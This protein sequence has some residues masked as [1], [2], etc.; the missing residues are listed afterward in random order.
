MNEILLKAIAA[1]EDGN[2]KKAE[3]FY[4]TVLQT[5]PSS[6]NVNFNLGVLLAQLERLD[7]AEKFYKKAI[8]SKPD[9][10]EAHNNLGILFD[11]TE[12][13]EDSEECYKKAILSKPDFAEAHNNLGN[14]LF[15][16]GKLKDSEEC[17]KKA[18]TLK[19]DF[20]DAH[21]NICKL[22]N[23]RKEDQQLIQMQKLYEDQSL[24]K[25]KHIRLCFTLGKVFED[26]NEINKSFRYYTEGNS[27]HKKTLNY[28]IKQD[29]QEF[30]KLKKSYKDIKKISIKDITLA[31]EPK[32]IFIVG[33]PR[34]GTSL[35][36]QIISSHSKVTGAGELS[37]IAE[38]GHSIAVGDSRI[39]AE[40]IL[41][42]RKKYLKKIQ[43]LSNENSVVIDKMPANF[44][45][46]GL[47]STAFPKAK[48][49]HVKRDSAATCWGNYK[50]FFNREVNLY[51][52]DLND[53]IIYYKLYLNLMNLWKREYGKQIYTLNY[54]SL[55][56]K[57]EYKTRKLIEFLDLEWE[58][59]CLEPENN[60]RRVNTASKRQIR[61]K[62]YQNSSAEWKKFEPFLNG[63]F[64]QLDNNKS[65][66]DKL[67]NLI[68]SIRKFIG[69]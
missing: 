7:E 24:P 45:Y 31:T 20:V 40:A 19:P 14:K 22:K 25:E 56:I 57:Q 37:Y 11:K 63:I 64:N 69:F 28:S 18:L 5:H 1:H 15:E 38:F 43:K 41:N 30:K 55:V 54:E 50:N 23:F 16:I 6:L 62:V 2:F 39:D 3:S 42:F 67:K 49:V 9:F 36:E 60:T 47:I 27:V 34:S 46:L 33:M 53:L 59:K 44:M 61:Q 13:F 32:L 26:L 65:M 29:I 17:Y 21:F 66:I 51:S 10:A 4:R 12:R 35:I 68:P 58:N 8:L 52:Y 48:I